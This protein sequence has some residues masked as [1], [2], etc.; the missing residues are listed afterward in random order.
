M[1]S[2]KAF[3]LFFLAALLMTPL[4][5]QAEVDLVALAPIVLRLGGPESLRMIG[6][7]LLDIAEWFP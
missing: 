2:K 4:A 5:A 1:H 3:R 7:T 6:E